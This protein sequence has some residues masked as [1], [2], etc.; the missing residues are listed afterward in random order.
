[1]ID[2]EL[3]RYTSGHLNRIANTLYEKGVEPNWVTL[4]GLAL[5]FLCFRSL[6]IR[7]ILFGININPN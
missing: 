5:A 4:L 1:M 3:N 7:V 2:R 6:I